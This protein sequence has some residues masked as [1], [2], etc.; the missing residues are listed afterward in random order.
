VLRHETSGGSFLWGIA[1]G[2]RRLVAVG[3]GGTILTST[4]GRNWNRVG[5][6][7]TDSL[8]AVTY[9]DGRFVAVGANGTIL[10]SEHGA[11]WTRATASGTTERLNNVIWSEGLYVAVG[12]HGVIVTSTNAEV[13]TLRPS[14]KTGWLRGLLASPAGGFSQSWT[15]GGAVRKISYPKFLAAGEGGIAIASLDGIQWDLADAP[16]VNW[17]GPDSSA[18]DVETLNEK[19]GRFIGAGSSGFVRSAVPFG[20]GTVAP[21]WL[22]ERW[23]PTPENIRFRGSVIVRDT[24]Y[25]FGE[26]GMVLGSRLPSEEWTQ[27]YN[28]TRASLAAGYSLGNSFFVVCENETILQSVRT[29]AGRLI[30]LSSRGVAGKDD[31]TLISGFVVQGSQPKRVLLRAVG[32]GLSTLA[33]IKG[34]VADPQLTLLDASHREIAKNA[35]WANADNAD[36]IRRAATEV[37]AFPLAAADRDAALVVTLE[38]GLYTA[39]VSPQAGA[40][41]LCLVEVYDADDVRSTGSKAINIS[42]RAQVGAGDS[43]LIAGL[44]VSGPL[45]RALLIRGVGPALKARFGMNGVLEQPRLKLV[46]HSGTVVA[47][48]DAW[49]EATQVDAIRTAAK[50]VGAFDLDEGSKDSALLVTLEPGIYTVQVSGADGGSGMA[51]VEVYDLP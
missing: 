5:S 19:D 48:V 46:S 43:I 15:L 3:G 8:M 26:E 20:G 50:R 16:F 31:P 2:D 21:T 18:P 42:T 6:G 9:G 40:S 41:G 4:D 22:S 28:P 14:G 13:W 27:V 39:L 25:V 17:T 1:E 33:G 10:L 44:V 38:P 45:P 12:E 35:G 49:S 37:G 24:L 36:E 32:P 30:N 11:Q 29:D 7:T 47:T 51:L 34:V 23:Y